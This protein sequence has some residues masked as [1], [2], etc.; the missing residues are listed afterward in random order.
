MRW[1]RFSE[2]FPRADDKTSVSSDDQVI[3]RGKTADG[4]W[5]CESEH[6]DT[7]YEDYDA[8]GRNEWLEDA[9]EVDVKL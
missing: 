3:V 6:L 4:E 5:Y 8:N 7:I 1:V 2:R 9:F